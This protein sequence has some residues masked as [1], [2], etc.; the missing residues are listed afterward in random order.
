MKNLSQS[1][2]SQ[3][4]VSNEVDPTELPEQPEG[5]VWQVVCWRIQRI[6]H[7]FQWDLS[8]KKNRMPQAI[9]FGTGEIPG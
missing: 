4:L 8:A 6:C 2:V 9:G 7:Q 1:G 5:L 3:L